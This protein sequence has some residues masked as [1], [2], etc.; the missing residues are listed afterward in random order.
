MRRNEPMAV[1]GDV[2]MSHDTNAL[3]VPTSEH[4]EYMDRYY[5]N[6]R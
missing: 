1:P 4:I 3:R 2:K 6:P 5:G